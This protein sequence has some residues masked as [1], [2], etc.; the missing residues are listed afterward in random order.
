MWQKW[1]FTRNNK[2][3]LIGRVFQIVTDHRTLHWFHSFKNFDGLTTRWLEKV[4]VLEYE[5][6]QRSWKSIGRADSMSRFPSWHTTMDQAHELTRG[7][8]AKH[9]LQKK[10]GSKLQRMTQPSSHARGIGTSHLTE[11]VK[12]A[13]IPATASLYESWWTR[14]NS[15]T[16]W[17]R[18]DSLPNRGFKEI[19]MSRSECSSL[20]FP[21]FN[22]T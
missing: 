1:I 15:T 22:S 8:E 11:K 12:E 13:K 9:P 2:F 17:V 3:Y 21:S 14:E 10:L 7:A 16:F 20:W 5:I 18:W 19:R 6:I 4:A